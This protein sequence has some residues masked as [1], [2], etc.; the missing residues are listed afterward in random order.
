MF[1]NTTTKKNNNNMDSFDNFMTDF[2]DK[3]NID[4]TKLLEKRDVMLSLFVYLV[5]QLD[6]IVVKDFCYNCSSTSLEL[7]SDQEDNIETGV[8]VSGVEES[9]VSLDDLINMVKESKPNTTTTKLFADCYHA[10]MF[11]L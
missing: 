6:Y 3:Y 11:L 2:C 10:I 5:D 7:N 4:K 8:N 1:F 9:L